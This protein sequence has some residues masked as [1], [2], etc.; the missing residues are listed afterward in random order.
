YFRQAEKDSNSALNTMDDRRQDVLIAN[1]YI[2]D[3]IWPGYQIEFSVTSNNDGPSR[4]FE[5]NSFRLR[6]ANQGIFQPHNINTVYFGLGTDGH[7]ERYNLS[8]QLYYVVGHDTLNPLANAPQDISAAMA[9]IELSYDRDWA[10]FRTSFFWSSG[11]H[12]TN[13]HKATAF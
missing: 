11:D 2:Q 10:R 8:T 9:S 12:N 5:T 6:P 13:N 3:F 4:R 7:I 1:Y